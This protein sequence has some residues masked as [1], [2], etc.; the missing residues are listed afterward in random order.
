MKFFRCVFALWAIM[1]ATAHA[2]VSDTDETNRLA[3]KSVASLVAPIADQ[4]APDDRIRLAGCSADTL[5]HGVSNK[6]AFIDARLCA[7]IEIDYEEHGKLLENLDIFGSVGVLMMVYANGQGVARNIPLAKRYACELGGASAELEGRLAH[8]DAIA[9][10]PK[11]ADTL[12]ICDDITSGYMMGMCAAHGEAAATLG[13]DTRWSALT[14]K[15]SPAE[16]AALAQLRAH[17]KTFFQSRVENEVDF[18][19]SARGALAIGE[20]N[21]LEDA[22]LDSVDAFESGKLPKFTVKQLKSADA[23]LNKSYAAARAAATVKPGEED[24]GPLGTI[25]PD[26]IRTT[27]RN[28]V[29]YRDAWVKFGALKYPKV[30]AEAWLTWLTRERE[31]QLRALYEGA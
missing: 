27:E 18:S 31:K 14:A 1:A 4:P 13:R 19:G 12:A 16:I 11:S 15:W 24:F 23:A 29:K 17:S 5:Y 6:P 20:R 9:K 7:F 26:G 21:N 10:R 28:W 22:F 3:C 25:R 2:Q 30:T 8:L